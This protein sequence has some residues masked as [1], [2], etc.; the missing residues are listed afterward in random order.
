MN[1]EILTK[2]ELKENAQ[3]VRNEVKLLVDGGSNPQKTRAVCDSGKTL[4]AFKRL[5]LDMGI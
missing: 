4:I 1:F 2:E 3:L 5:E